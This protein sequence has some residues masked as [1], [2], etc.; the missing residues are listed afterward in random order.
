MCRAVNAFINY[1][2]VL[3]TGLQTAQSEGESSGESGMEEE[4]R[5]VVDTIHFTLM[6]TLCTSSDEYLVAYKALKH[7]LPQV[8]DVVLKLSQNSPK[9]ISRLGNKACLLLMLPFARLTY[10]HVDWCWC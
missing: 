4:S 3:Q 1:P 7:L 5:C 6:L 10:A 2:T 9:N 8:D